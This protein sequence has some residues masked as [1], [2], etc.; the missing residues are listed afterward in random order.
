MCK[1]YIRVWNPTQDCSKK[2]VSFGTLFL[3]PRFAIT[4]TS[5]EPASSSNL[6][7]L[8]LSRW[9]WNSWDSSRITSGRFSN[10]KN[11]K[12]SIAFCRQQAPQ[13]EGRWSNICWSNSGAID[14]D[15]DEDEDDDDDEDECEDDNYLLNNSG[16]A[17]KWSIP[18][19]PE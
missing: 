17:S 8:R 13:L 15:D 5:S 2:I 10:N 3:K 12:N 1:F 6:A 19:T 14:E 4:Q 18:L 7:L 16:A 11:L 9:T